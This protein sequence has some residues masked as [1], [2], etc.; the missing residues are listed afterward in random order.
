MG[1]II[2]RRVYQG[3]TGAASEF[4]HMNHVPD[5]ARCMCGRRGCLE[6]YA[7]NYAILRQVLG[8]DEDDPHNWM[9]YGAADTNEVEARA[10]AGDALALAA[11]DRAGR[12]LG[13]GI[14][15]M[16]ALLN[17][18]RVVIAGSGAGAADLLEQPLRTGFADA[19]VETLRKDVDMTFVP[20]SDDLILRGTISVLLRDIDRNLAADGQRLSQ[21]QFAREQEH[22]RGNAEVN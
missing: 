12:A 6:A 8:K 14:G 17:P 2:N 16:V 21:Q 13:F 19:V 5:G 22:D 10:R 7:G 20:H 9:E 15:R 18:A 11:Y 3:A 4:G 1:M